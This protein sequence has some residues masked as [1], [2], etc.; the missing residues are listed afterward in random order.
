MDNQKLISIDDNA[1]ESVSGGCLLACLIVKPVALV[2]NLLS[3]LLG[4]CQPPKSSCEPKYNDCSPRPR[5][6]C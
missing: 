4:G 1:L 3:S 2:T 5:H 6:R